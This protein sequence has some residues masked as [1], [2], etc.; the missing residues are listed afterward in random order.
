MEADMNKRRAFKE[1]LFHASLILTS[2][3]DTADPLVDSATGEPYGERDWD[4]FCQH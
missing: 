1:G 4:A 2:A 3:M